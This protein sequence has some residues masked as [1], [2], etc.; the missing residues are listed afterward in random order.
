MVCD[1]NLVITCACIL[2]ILG[3]ILPVTLVFA[4]FA[5]GLMRVIVDNNFPNADSEYIHLDAPLAYVYLSSS[6][7]LLVTYL[8]YYKS[9][10]NLCIRR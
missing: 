7:T 5:R 6:N 4:L 1:L 2:L 8:I 10:T 9:I 3:L